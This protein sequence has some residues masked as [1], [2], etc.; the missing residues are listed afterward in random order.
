[1]LSAWHRIAVT[2]AVASNIMCCSRRSHCLKLSATRAR[3]K[4]HRHNNDRCPYYYIKSDTPAP[5]KELK[6]SS[7][8]VVAI[9]IDKLGRLVKIESAAF[10]NLLVM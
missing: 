2:I 3:I 5:S 10:D 6:A 1:M 9:N 4:G 8:T 7:P